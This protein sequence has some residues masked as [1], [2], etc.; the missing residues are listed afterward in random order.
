MTVQFV[1]LFPGTVAD[2]DDPEHKCRIKV[3]VAELLDGPTGW[4]LP[5]LPFA[6][7][8]CGFAVVPPVGASVLVQWPRGDLSAQPVWCGAN[9]NAGASVDGAGPNTLII[10]TPGGHRVELSDDGTALTLTCSAGPVITMD[11]AGVSIDNGSGA[12]IVMNAGTV[13]INDGALVVSSGLL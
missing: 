2:N 7:D 12:T 5:A 6:G 10:Q 13:D 3:R 9:F 1:G 4:C 8:G 11:S